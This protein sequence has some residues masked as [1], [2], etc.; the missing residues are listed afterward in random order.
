MAKNQIPK[1]RC[2]WRRAQED[3]L[4]AMVLDCLI[5]LMSRDP[6]GGG[7]ILITAPFSSEHALH[8]RCMCELSHLP[9]LLA[10]VQIIWVAWDI[11]NPSDTAS[12]WISP[13][14]QHQSEMQHSTKD[15]GIAAFAESA[16]GIL[17]DLIQH[18]GF[19]PSSPFIMLCQDWSRGPGSSWP[20]RLPA[21][22][23]THCNP[24]NVRKASC[25]TPVT[26]WHNLSQSL[27]SLMQT[28][29][30]SSTPSDNKIKGDK[31]HTE[32]PERQFVENQVPNLS[33]KINTS[34]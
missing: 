3:S 16:T 22:G 19:V 30:K 33:F 5:L 26:L 27:Q 2:P 23:T 20:Y 24:K 31:L 17:L 11:R 29:G 14:L 4:V 13:A 12:S 15:C 6:V 21:A 1:D 28:L 7:W 10:V 32:V 25:L 18:H 9:S 34:R 8:N